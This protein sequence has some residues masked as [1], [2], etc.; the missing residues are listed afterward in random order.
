MSSAEEIKKKGLEVDFNRKFLGTVFRNS[1][2]DYVYSISNYSIDD[3]KNDFSC[4]QFL[5]EP[6][7]SSDVE[8]LMKKSLKEGKD[9]LFEACKERPYNEEKAFKDLGLI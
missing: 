4:R 2:G 7:Q 5:L 3:I 1:L 6:L 9:F 8:K